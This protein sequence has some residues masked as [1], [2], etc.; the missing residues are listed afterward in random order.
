MFFQKDPSIFR[1]SFLSAGN[2][3][4]RIPLPIAYEMSWLCKAVKIV[5][6]QDIHVR[7]GSEDETCPSTCRFSWE[8]PKDDLQYNVAV[9]RQSLSCNRL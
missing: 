5:D 7:L 1:L 9:A 4:N 3:V 6:T 8:R 2:F